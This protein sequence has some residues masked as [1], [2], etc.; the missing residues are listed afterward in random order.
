[1]KFSQIQQEDRRRVILAALKNE[2]DYSI[3]EYVISEVLGYMGHGVSQDTVRTEL[4]WLKEQ[5]LITIKADEIQVA[6]ITD[7]GVDVA[8]GLATVPGVKRPR[9]G[10]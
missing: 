5:G 7:R 9:P 3:N 4:A 2:P 10:A 6:T 8:N 1:M